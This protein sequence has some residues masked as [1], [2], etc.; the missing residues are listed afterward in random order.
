MVRPLKGRVVAVIG[1]DEE[2]VTFTRESA[3]QLRHPLVEATEIFG[4]A[5]RIPPVAV[6]GVEVHEVGEDQAAPNTP[7]S[8]DDGTDLRR[9]V[10]F[11]QQVLRYALAVED[12]PNLAYRDNLVPGVLDEIHV[13]IRGW[14]DA[15]IV[16]VVVLAFVGA[17]PAVVGAGD[18]PLDEDLPF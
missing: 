10:G 9:I 3:E 17:P 4:H 11:A 5:P 8:F 6:P 16:A 2:E 12:V 18:H 1:G 14:G 15:V 13:R 7:Q